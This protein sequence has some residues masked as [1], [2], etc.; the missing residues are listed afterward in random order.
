MRP[1]IVLSDGMVYGAKLM[2]GVKHLNVC[3]TPSGLKFEDSQMFYTR[4]AVRDLTPPFGE[5]AIH[6]Q[7][8]IGLKLLFASCFIAI[9]DGF[10][11]LN[12]T[13]KN[14]L[15]K[16]LYWVH[17]KAKRDGTTRKIYSPRPWVK[18]I[19]K[20]ILHKLDINE[21]YPKHVF[22]VS[23]KGI[24]DAIR[25]LGKPK[26]IVELDIK[27]AYPSTTRQMIL[28]V[29]SKYFEENTRSAT[30]LSRI[31][32]PNYHL[33]IG[34]P[35][36]PF[37]FNMVLSEVDELCKKII[38][39]NGFITIMRYVDNIYV[40]AGPIDTARRVAEEISKKLTSLSYSV[41]QIELPSSILSVST[42]NM[43]VVDRIWMKLVD[44]VRDNNIQV[45]DG[46][47]SYMSQFY[48]GA[49]KIMKLDSKEKTSKIQ[50]MIDSRPAVDA[51][52]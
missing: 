34:Y 15:H 10:S 48:P 28:P 45:V 35:T 37:M 50:N 13:K 2:A 11:V 47:L 8:C 49:K 14:E 29:I 40:N 18:R 16:N 42:D 12:Y 44:S 52:L 23:K 33:P 5:G 19:L 9:K 51:W 20:K 17:K 21:T 24:G 41:R 30:E 3:S 32:A 26:N 1:Q 31:L 43:S 36:S 46:M 39:D 27:S 4:Y 38:E 22:G 6:K 7:K 25:F